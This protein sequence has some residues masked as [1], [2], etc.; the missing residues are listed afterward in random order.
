MKSEQWNVSERSVLWA[1]RSVI[2]IQLLKSV[3]NEILNSRFIH[4]FILLY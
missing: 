3:Q 2:R 1:D 4:S